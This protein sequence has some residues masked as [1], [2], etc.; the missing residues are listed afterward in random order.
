[1]GNGSYFDYFGS[2]AGEAEFVSVG[3]TMAGRIYTAEAIN[4]AIRQRYE[5][6]GI[7]MT[8]NPPPAEYRIDNQAGSRTLRRFV[9]IFR[10]QGVKAEVPFRSPS[11]PGVTPLEVLQQTR[12]AMTYTNEHHPEM[13]GPN[14]AKALASVMQAIAA[15][16]GKAT[17]TADGTPIIQ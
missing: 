12:A 6:E 7:K 2:E 5:N 8:F 3:A 9:A 10:Y 16:E 14:D 4:R 11:L 15:I 13:T 17:E 1:M